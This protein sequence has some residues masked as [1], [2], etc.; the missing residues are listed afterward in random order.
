VTK[1]PQ[2]LRMSYFYS[3]HGLSVASE[4]HLPELARCTSA[5]ASADVRFRLS[6]LPT[7]ADAKSTTVPHLQTVNE[8]ALLTVENAARYLVR[9]GREVLIDVDAQADLALVRLVL[10]G[11]VMGMICYQRGLLVLHAS[12]VAIGGRVVAFTGPPGAGKST[13]AAH[14]L[15]EG[16]R[17][18]ADDVLVVSVDD[19]R[20][21]VAHPGMPSVKLWRDT[22]ANLGRDPEGLRPDWYRADKFHMPVDHAEERMPLDRLYVLEP[23]DAAGPGKL[24][25]L[26]GAFAANAIIVNSYRIEYLEAAGRRDLHFQQC[27]ELARTI[28]VVRLS[29]SRDL[30]H[31]QTTAALVIADLEARSTG[32]RDARAAR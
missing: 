22:I 9:D 20:G 4:L 24:S 14:C 7:F 27:T 5:N 8:D 15:A 2:R 3:V 32:K 29:R 23:D 30:K 25:R 26:T 28:E 19:A 1:A 16:G 12:A 21:A 13:L 11:S 18:V 10:F 31:V 6:S 17:L